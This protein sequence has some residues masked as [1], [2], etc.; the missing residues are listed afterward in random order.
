MCG[1]DTLVCAVRQEAAYG[2]GG[3]RVG[4]IARCRVIAERSATKSVDDAANKGE[5]AR[6]TARSRPRSS[7]RND[8]A[9]AASLRSIEQLYPQ[10]A[11]LRSGH[12]P[13]AWQQHVARVSDDISASDGNVIAAMINAVRNLRTP[14]L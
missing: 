3:G 10:P 12:E 11:C 4:G 14:R 1:T 9:G 6:N 7:A 2:R 8:D 5:V 13:D